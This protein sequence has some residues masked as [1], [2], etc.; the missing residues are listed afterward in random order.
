MYVV[1]SCARNETARSSVL[2]V[3]AV[4]CPL[5]RDAL[6]QE[7]QDGHAGTPLPLLNCCLVASQPPAHL[8]LQLRR[9]WTAPRRPRNLA[10][11]S[12][13][14]PSP[15]SAAPALAR[16]KTMPRHC[17]LASRS[18]RPQPGSQPLRGAAAAAPSGPAQVVRGASLLRSRLPALK[19]SNPV[20]LEDE[21]LLR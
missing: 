11:E 10:A 16:P 8:P 19:P 3:A 6:T 18:P 1:Q 5:I 2:A 15:P 17:F 20:A 12:A 14:S 7:P 21:T 13:P 9:R 4:S